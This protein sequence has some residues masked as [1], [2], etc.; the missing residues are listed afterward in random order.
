MLSLGLKL[1]WRNRAVQTNHAALPWSN[2]QFRFP[3]IEQPLPCDTDP[4]TFE[5]STDG[6]CYVKSWGKLRR[7]VEEGKTQQFIPDMPFSTQ[8]GLS[9]DL[10][11][12]TSDSIMTLFA[13]LSP[14]QF[15][16]KRMLE[17]DYF[18]KYSPSQAE[19]R[20]SKVPWF[21]PLFLRIVLHLCPG[22]S[23]GNSL[24]EVKD[25]KSTKNLIFLLFGFYILLCN[26]GRSEI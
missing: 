19:R 15:S 1:L 5:G 3:R 8:R 21:K 18:Q 12:G 20:S 14:W 17:K 7:E 24:R 16:S 4:V 2:I 25:T 26:E 9:I 13:V 22:V 10:C 11:L 6:S 23:F